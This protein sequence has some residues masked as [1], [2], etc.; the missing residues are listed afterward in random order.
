MKSEVFNNNIGSPYNSFEN[1]NLTKEQDQQIKAGLFEQ[2]LIFDRITISTNRLNFGLTFLI[3][4]LGLAI[5]ER[6]IDCGYIQFMIYSPILVTG[7]GRKMENGTIDISVIYD[8]PPIAAGS[9]S[10]EDLEPDR[11]IHYALSNFDL[12]REIKRNFTKKAVKSYIIPDGMQISTSSEKL[13]IDAYLNNN[14]VNLGLPFEKEPQKLELE[15]RA[16]LLEL[17]HKVIETSILSKY[18]LKSYENIE[19]FE[20]CRQNFSN[21]GKAFNIANNTSEILKFEN[22]PNLRELYI[23]EKLDFESIFKIRHLPTA[24]YYRKWINEVGENS[25]CSEVTEAYINEIKGKGKFLETGKGKF[26]KNLSSF[27]ISTGLGTAIG[28][29]VGATV[30]ALLQ[31]VADYGL[32]LLETFWLDNFLKGKNPSMFVEELKKQING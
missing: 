29:V 20:I 31:P 18:N 14:L 22:V 15:Q 26:I 32:G 2:L 27:G 21:I 17:G 8:Q 11:N 3:N 12:S 7:Q 1:P 24:K 23:N 25:N 6:L 16:I 10:N 19:H 5:V 30:G 28:G 13:V 4:R 9:L